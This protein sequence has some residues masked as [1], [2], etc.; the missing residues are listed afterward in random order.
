MRVGPEEGK[1]ALYLTR[2]ER[3][4]SV[5]ALTRPWAKGEKQGRDQ[6]EG[7]GVR[8]AISRARVP[9]ARERRPRICRMTAG[10]FP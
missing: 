2:N 1:R 4:L 9:V 8:A 6:G 3:L 5:T 7:G 10:D